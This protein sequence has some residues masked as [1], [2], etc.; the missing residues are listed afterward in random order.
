VRGD[1]PRQSQ[2]SANRNNEIKEIHRFI[3][4]SSEPLPLEMFRNSPAKKQNL[5]F[6]IQIHKKSLVFIY[7]AKIS[8]IMK[9]CKK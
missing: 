9:I 1:L 2:Y 6:I 7:M 5:A 4:A 3:T 8:G